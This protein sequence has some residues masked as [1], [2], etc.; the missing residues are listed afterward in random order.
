MER[1]LIELQIKNAVTRLIADRDTLLAV[2]DL[3]SFEVPGAHF[4][5]KTMPKGRWDGRKRL[6]RAD[7]SFPAGLTGS[8]INY[9]LKAKVKIDTVTDFRERPSPRYDW[10]FQVPFTPRDYQT[11]AAKLTDDRVRGIFVVGTGGGKTS[12]AT[13]ITQRRGVD[14]LFVAPDTGLREQVFETFARFF[15][16][17]EVSM[18]LQSR[19]PIVVTNIQAIGAFLPTKNKLTKE[20]KPPKKDPKAFARFGMLLVDEFHH[21]ASDRYLHLNRLASGAYWRYGL[22]GTFIRPDGKDMIMHGV[23]SNILVTMT[24]SDLIDA[25]WLVPADVTMHKWRAKGYSRFSYK[26]AYKRIVTDGSFNAFVA[27]RIRERVREEGKQT[28]VLVRYK[29]H[30]GLLKDML[31]GDALYVDGDDTALVRER[32]KRLFSEKKIKCLIATNIFGEGQDIPSIDCLINARLQESEIQ[33]KQGIGRALRLAAGAR[34]YEE[35]ITLGKSRAH[36]E[37]FFIEGN[38][39]LKDHSESRIEQYRSERAFRIEIAGD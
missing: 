3:L 5:M 6:M 35:S 38:R 27:A 12:I 2:S 15:G 33:T 14:T 20:V 28:L 25:G 39:Y 21:A 8:V 16:P 32:A 7:G 23:L 37:D 22:T 1:A 26:E 31:A 30:G 11:A 4:A 19:A 34:N 9:F 24:T 17:R 29:E 36:V 18:D 13:M 10:K